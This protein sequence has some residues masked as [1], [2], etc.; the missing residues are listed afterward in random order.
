MQ[1]DATAAAADRKRQYSGLDADYVCHLI[2]LFAAIVR[3]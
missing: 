2:E 3:E 1:I